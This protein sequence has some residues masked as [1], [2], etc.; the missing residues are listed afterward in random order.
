MVRSDGIIITMTVY[1]VD[2]IVFFLSF[3]NSRC[4]M[5]QMYAFSH[6]GYENGEG[7]FVAMLKHIL[8]DR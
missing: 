5:I 2:V 8:F 6:T 4:F 7:Q 3:D 1:I